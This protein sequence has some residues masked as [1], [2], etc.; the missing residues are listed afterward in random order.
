MHIL[1][2]L[3]ILL[4]LT[5]SYLIEVTLKIRQYTS[6]LVTRQLP[7]HPAGQAWVR[8]WYAGVLLQRTL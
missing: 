1:S 6:A 7:A 5:L 4:Y 8:L 2:Y 3:I